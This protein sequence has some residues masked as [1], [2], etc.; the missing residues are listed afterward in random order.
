MAY[1]LLHR[2][3]TTLT[4]GITR[5]SSN[6]LGVKSRTHFG[7]VRVQ[8]EKGCARRLDEF[9]GAGKSVYSALYPPSLLLWALMPANAAVLIHDAQCCM[10][11]SLRMRH[12]A[13]SRGIILP[14]SRGRL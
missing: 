4:A 11:D 3:G 2:R 1:P 10:Y 5:L 8:K 12:S 7:V 13:V 14:G 9:A 6:G